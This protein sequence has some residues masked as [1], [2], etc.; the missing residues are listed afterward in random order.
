[1]N[2]YV[3]PRVLRETSQGT[4]RFSLPDLM[5][6]RREIWLSGEID[7]NL[8]DGV[9]SQILHLDAELPQQEI[10]LY[11][12]SPG[13]SVSAGLAIYD[14]MQAVPSPI[15]TVC[16]GLAASM[17]AILFAAGSTRQIL[18]HGEVMLHDPLIHNGVSGTALT[19]QDT[20]E[21]LMQVRKSLCN[22]LAKHTGKSL[23]QIYKVTAKDTYF[24]AEA[25][26]Q[27]GLADT[28]L[29]KFER[30]CA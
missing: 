27:F 7:S 26:I 1:M 22:I 25:A 28:I 10:T 13:G 21:R 24:S 30:S 5:L 23:K 14:V 9:I 11:I 20:S 2:F 29:T 15:R 16:V 17:A 18:P 6:Q 4:E 8:A 12:D 3:V 19:V